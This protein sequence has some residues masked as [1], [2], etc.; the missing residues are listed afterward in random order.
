MAGGYSIVIFIRSV[1]V[2]RPHPHR[3]ASEEGV[4]D[5]IE[6]NTRLLHDGRLEECLLESKDRHGHH[7]DAA[8]LNLGLP[9]EGGVAAERVEAE[10]T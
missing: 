8:V 2:H 7:G 4:P 6:E 10:D 3:T 5:R 1:T 9:E